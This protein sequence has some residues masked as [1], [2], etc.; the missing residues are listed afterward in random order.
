MSLVSRELHIGARLGNDT[1]SWFHGNPIGS[2]AVTC[3]P[4]VPLKPGGGYVSL[5]SPSLTPAKRWLDNRQ[6]GHI[7]MELFGTN[8]LWVPLH[9]GPFG[10]GDNYY[11]AVVTTEYPEDT[12]VRL[13]GR[14][15][16][17]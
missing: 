8:V 16:A 5:F 6:I 15:M 1:L 4:T 12:I 3:S 7:Q 13:W 11:A 9:T 2:L 17:S 10:V 14:R